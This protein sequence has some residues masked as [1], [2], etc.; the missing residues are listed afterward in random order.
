M[1]TRICKEFRT[2][3]DLAGRALDYL[4]DRKL[5]A[6]ITDE[7]L[8]RK[9]PETTLVKWASTFL[10]INYKI[11]YHE[12]D[13]LYELDKA[14]FDTDFSATVLMAVTNWPVWVEY[15]NSVTEEDPEKKNSELSVVA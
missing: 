9:W 3:W 5:N 1:K 14:V 7:E 2:H 12:M 10:Q 8:R 11:S 4:K 15:L 13:A 6:E